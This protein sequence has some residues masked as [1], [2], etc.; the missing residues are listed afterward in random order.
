MS[1]SSGLPTKAR[2]REVPGETK[3]LM[4]VPRSASQSSMAQRLPAFVHAAKDDLDAGRRAQ[5][6]D[7]A[8]FVLAFDVARLI[9][10]PARLSPALLC[11]EESPGVG[12]SQP[13][14][15]LEPPAGVER[16]CERSEGELCDFGVTLNQSGA[17]A[18]LS[19]PGRSLAARGAP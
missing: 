1:E 9:L 7:P 14:P 19:V 3:A 11:G 12:E 2:A 6:P 18:S 8:V 10:V 5:A 15:G 16:R 4:G 17:S 13:G